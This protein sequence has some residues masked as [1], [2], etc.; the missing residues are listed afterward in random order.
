VGGR[1]PCLAAMRH[2]DWGVAMGYTERRARRREWLAREQEAAELRRTERRVRNE[3][4]HEFWH[5]VWRDARPVLRLVMVLMALA[6]CGAI[7]L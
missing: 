3:P 5:A 2:H 1:S 7:A 4:R 6:V